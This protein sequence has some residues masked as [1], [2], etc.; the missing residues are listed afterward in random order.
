[1][2]YFTKKE[3]VLWCGSVLLIIGSFLIFDKEN[4]MTL[5]ASL[6]GATSIIISAKGNPIG[7]CLWRYFP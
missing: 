3:I 7:Q 4:Y 5:L 6:I 1:M 2:K